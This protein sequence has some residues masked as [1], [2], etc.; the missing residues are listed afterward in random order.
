MKEER[1]LVQVNGE[2]LDAQEDLRR[3]AGKIRDA[4][5]EAKRDAPVVPVTH[6]EY[7]QDRPSDLRFWVE[8]GDRAP[9]GELRVPGDGVI[10][11]GAYDIAEDVISQEL[12]QRTYWRERLA[13]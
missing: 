2:K 13:D 1:Q 9:A 10:A 5:L 3:A 8:S 4:L 12:A 6:P 7:G 11:F